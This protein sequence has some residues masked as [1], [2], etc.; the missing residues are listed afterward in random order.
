MSS[1]RRGVVLTGVVL[2]ELRSRVRSSWIVSLLPRQVRRPQQERTVLEALA[3]VGPAGMTPNALEMSTELPHPRLEAALQPLI[4][5][6]LVRRWERPAI[7]P[8]S[9]AMTEPQGRIYTLA[10]YTI[11]DREY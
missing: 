1:Y 9:G 2:A 3:E 5:D 11:T 7:E 10:E 6:G 8:G 4:A